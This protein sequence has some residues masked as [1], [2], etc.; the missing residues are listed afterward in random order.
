MDSKPLAPNKHPKFRLLLDVA[1]AK[2]F[3]F[4][5]LIKKAVVKHARLD[6]KLS[7]QTEDRE[8]YNR[9]VKLNMFVTTI[10][11]KDFKR[12]V[13]KKDK[14]GVL[15]IDSGLTNDE[16]DEVLTKFVTGK[17]PLDYYGKATVVR[18]T[19]LNLLQ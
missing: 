9:A 7:P 11:Y 8:V 13:V 2:P 18:R 16:I 5:R 3:T 17:N 6:L 12:F 10:N 19:T 4:K 1:F 15:A 14:P